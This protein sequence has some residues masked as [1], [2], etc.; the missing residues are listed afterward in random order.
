MKFYFSEKGIAL[1]EGDG[2]IETRIICDQDEALWVE[3]TN[4]TDDE[5]RWRD[6]RSLYELVPEEIYRRAGTCY[7]RLY[8]ERRNK[9]CSVCGNKLENSEI[10]SKICPQ[11]GNEVWPQINIAII[12]L[13]ERGEEALLVRARNFR[14]KDF[15]GLVAGFVELG[16]S[17]EEA[18]V[19]EVREETGLGIK[20]LR[21][22]SSQ[23]WPYPSGLMVGFRAQWENG[24]LRL[25]E[26]ELE[27]GG[28]F[29]RDALPALPDR[30]SIAR[31]LIEE[32]R[33]EG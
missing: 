3:K 25:L 6:L 5:G 16:E 17:L 19:R 26:S 29:R 12:V 9:Y 4:D 1:E 10:G 2:E 7:E 11:C 30:L 20:N 27:R 13:I 31:K 21:Y 28:W 23:P 18:V 33:Q 15:Y 24:D 14:R 32:W 22:R 8:F